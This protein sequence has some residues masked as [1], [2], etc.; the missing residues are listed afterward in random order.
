MKEGSRIGAVEGFGR[1]TCFNFR[2]QVIYIHSGNIHTWVILKGRERN[3]Y[4]STSCIHG[5]D[6]PLSDCHIRKVCNSFQNICIYALV[7]WF[8]VVG[9]PL[10]DMHFKFVVVVVLARYKPG[11]VVQ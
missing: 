6:F 7:G 5:L 2:G 10:P 8:I 9:S 3:H 4:T 11:L 1:L